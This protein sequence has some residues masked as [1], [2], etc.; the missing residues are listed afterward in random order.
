MKRA[1]LAAAAVAALSAAAF[2]AAAN[3]HQFGQGLT[4]ETQDRCLDDLCQ[5]QT[6]LANASAPADAPAPVSLDAPRYGA[7]GFDLAGM[8]RSVNP[9]DNFYDYANGNWDKTTDIPSDLVRFGNFDKLRILSEARTKTII[10]DAMAGKFP[11]DPDAVRVGT[12]YGSFMDEKRA[13]MLDAKP[14][15]AELAGIRKAKT[16]KDLT[17]LMGLSNT[18]GY[19]SIFNF[20]IADDLKDPSHY[21]IYGGQGGLG[22]PDRDYYLEAKFADKKA[23]YEA[24]VAQI[25]TMIGWPDAA[26]QAKAIVAYETKLAGVYWSRVQLRD[27]DKIYNPTSLAELKA[28][29]PGVDWDLFMANQGLKGENRFIITTNSVFPKSAAI[30]NETPIETLKAWQAF[31]VADGAA[32]L[33]SKRFV[34]ANFE[35]RGKVLS[36]QP[37]QKPR[38]K[39][40]V[41]LVE[42]AMGEAVGRVYV[43]RYFTPAAKAKVEGLV[44][45]IQSALKNRI[46][47]LDWM[48]PETKA[49]ALDKL[50]K[51]TIKI[52][53]PDKWRDYSKLVMKKDDLYGNVQRAGVFEWNREKARLHGPVDKAEW[54]MTPQ[55]VNAYYNS[56]K[57]EI[58]FPAAILQP[59]FFDPQADMAVNYGGIGVVIGHEISHGFDD[60]GRK[61]DGDGVLRDWWTGEDTAKFNSQ[62]DKL[63]AQYSAFEPL[64]GMHVNGTLTMGENIGDMGGVSLALDAYHVFL[65]GQPAPVLD[66]FTGDQRVFLGFAQVWRDKIRDDALKL[67]LTTD[68]HSPAKVRVNATIRN[69]DGWYAAFGI[70]PGDKLYVAPADRVRIW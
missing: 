48:S 41:A 35:F 69:I 42:G 53:Y 22:L 5:T 2:T 1:L 12:A 65:N 31:R 40:G 68:P 13:D 52:A 27:R 17:G 67:R 36:G 25:L 51:F 32:P 62:R 19:A 70:K 4:L 61:S 15:A 8:D 10:E 45:D 14:I 58:V 54:G 33:L 11:T 37:E 9:G 64:P 60:Q 39:R 44:H 3:T 20:G 29:A 28:M 23:A 30:Y 21:A 24:Y 7:W 34:D 26:G 57:N 55:T 6:L 46:E 56:T 43:S 50:S 47:H 66:G 38:W 63:G 49:R 16:R 18:T 59:P